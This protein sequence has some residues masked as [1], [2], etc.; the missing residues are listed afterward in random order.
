MLDLLGKI[1]AYFIAFVFF[2]GC[3]SAIVLSL[4]YDPKE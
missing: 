3:L 1:F 2:A 4:G